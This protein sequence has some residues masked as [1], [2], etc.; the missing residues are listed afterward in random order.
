[1]AIYFNTQRYASTCLLLCTVYLFTATT[2]SSSLHATDNPPPLVLS[3]TSSDTTIMCGDTLEVD[4]R[5]VSGFDNLSVLEFRV[6]W[7]STLLA[8][9]DQEAM[10]IGPDS[11]FIGDVFAGESVYVW[12]E[13]A[14]DGE[15]L[16][17]GS[18]LLR[19]R[20]VAINSAGLT[21][22]SINGDPNFFVV[23]TPAFE[24]AVLIPDNSVEVTTSLI[25]LTV[26]QVP[27]VPFGVSTATLPYSG[28]TGMPTVYSIDYSA[29]AEA[30]SKKSF[31]STTFD[32][33]KVI[34]KFSFIK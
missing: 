1:M 30:D 23:L 31:V 6:N 8:L 25:A 17:P 22:I 7:D 29:A 15:T 32:L 24:D 3:V 9:V 11:V 26:G 5:V 14:F 16:S 2:L 21:S 20:L 19:I 28:T 12:L 13:D 18:L 4:I 27:P 34:V 10:D 33:Y